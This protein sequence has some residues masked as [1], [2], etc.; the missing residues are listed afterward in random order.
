MRRALRLCLLVA[1]AGA[2][3]AAEPVIAPAQA[4]QPE[5]R[6]PR[7]VTPGRVVPIAVT[8]FRPSSVI[9][10]QFGVYFKAPANCC[11]TTLQERRVRA[12]G[13]GVFS[14]RMPRRYAQCVTVACSD[15]H[16]TAWKPGQRI[17]IS[18]FPA[19]GRSN[20]YAKVL[21]RVRR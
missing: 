12:D 9:D 2:V 6:A 5:I 7:V 3:A 21:S 1:I 16:L 18:A 10:I 19:H 13:S 8:G 11:V 14:V 17:F 4:A 20:L 15:R